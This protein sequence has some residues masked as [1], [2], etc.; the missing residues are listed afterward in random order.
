MK[1]SI[2]NIGTA[3]DKAEQRTIN[4]GFNGCGT[5]SECMSS[6]IYECELTVNWHREP[7]CWAC[8]DNNNHQ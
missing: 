3:L 2:L 6:C 5:L 8:V 7:P 4:G 1:Q